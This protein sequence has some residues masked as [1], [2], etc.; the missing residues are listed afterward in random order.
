MVR[1]IVDRM[2]LVIWQ[3]LIRLTAIH[4]QRVTPI[5][6]VDRMGFVTNIVSFMVAVHIVIRIRATVES[7]QQD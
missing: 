2:Q 4:M 1:L 5:V 3:E 6:I 7:W